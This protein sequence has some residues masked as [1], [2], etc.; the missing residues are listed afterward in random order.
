MSRLT[1]LFVPSRL[2][3][4]DRTVTDVAQSN[5]GGPESAGGRAA[6]PAGSAPHFATTRERWSGP[7]PEG[8][9]SRKYR[10]RSR[11]RAANDIR[12]RPT[13]TAKA[14]EPASSSTTCEWRTPT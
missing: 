10:R 13:I 14:P 1:A 6:V 9:G 7:A 3:P 2:L 12:S 5:Y 4:T 11:S 8:S